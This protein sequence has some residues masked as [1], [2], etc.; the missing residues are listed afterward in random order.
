M[1][2]IG[3][4]DYYDSAMAYGRDTDIVFVRNQ[5]SIVPAN[6]DCPLEDRTLDLRIKPK[7]CAYFEDAD[8]YYSNRI[9]ERVEEVVVYFAGKRYGGLKFYV[10]SI[11]KNEL[12]YFWNYEDFKIFMAKKEIGFKVADISWRGPN[13]YGYTEE[14]MIKHFTPRDATKEE[15]DWLVANRVSIAI[16]TRNEREWNW[17][18]NSDRLSKL[19]F[20]RMLDPYTAFQELSM[21]VG[22]VL[23]RNPNP[24]VEITSEKVKVAKH[25]FDKWSFRKRSLDKA[26]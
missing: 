5:N 3:G 14:K 10:D 23:P 7:G 17:E 11:L 15:M 9:W 18:I 8:S 20:F 21:F 13:A 22:G 1:R 25:G 2:I 19:F 24:M 26:R 16:L 6:K 12:A 4:K